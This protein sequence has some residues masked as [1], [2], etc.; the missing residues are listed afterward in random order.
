M[1]MGGTG[2]KQEDQII[3]VQLEH[4]LGVKFTYVPF[5]GGRG[6]RQPGRQST[7]TPP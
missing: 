7:L 5:K 2:S 3:T 1:K 4:A 6:V